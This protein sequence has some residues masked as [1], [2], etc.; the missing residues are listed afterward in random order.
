M[1]APVSKGPLSGVTVIEMPALGPSPFCGM[2]LGD[3]G[4]EVIKIDRVAA[5]DLGI[6]F[7]PEYD[8][9]NR[10][11]RSVALDLKSAD[12]KEA[13]RALVAQ[14]DVV[15]EGFRPGVAERLGFGPDDCLALKPSLIYARAT[16]WGQDGPLAQTAGHDINYIALSG[17]LAMMGAADGPPAVPLNLLGDYA[18]GAMVMAFGIVCA[19]FQ[20]RASGQGQVVDAAMVDGVNTLLTVFH[21]FRQ[22]GMLHPRGQ[23]VLDGGAPYYRCYET[24]DGGWMAVGAI[25][26]KFYAEMLARLDLDPATLP[27]QNDRAGWPALTE[28]LAARFRERTRAEWEAVF[29]GS[30]ACV[31]PVL[32]LDESLTHPH[33]VAR[34]GIATLDGIEHPIPVPRLSRT[35]GRILSNAPKP[36]Q[37]TETVLRERGVPDAVIAAVLNGLG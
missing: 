25:E 10:N 11:K 32:S 37:D 2:M 4:A 21:G 3:M 6:A 12:G 8:L 34:G 23:N 13:L 28:A 20:A 22:A 18:G 17:A 5:S 14:A 35:P 27:G 9:R 15:I 31:S 30:D 19:L 16:G 36:G 29:D 26:A 24:R 1:N 7:P 33:A